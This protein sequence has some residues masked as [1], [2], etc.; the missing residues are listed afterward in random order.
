MLSFEIT[1]GWFITST[2]ATLDDAVISDLIAVRVYPDWFKEVTLEWQIPV[3]WGAYTVDVYKSGSSTTEYVKVTDAPSRGNTWAD[4]DTTQDS[5]Q[6]VDYYIIEVTLATGEIYRSH[7]AFVQGRRTRWAHIRA[8]E[9]SRRE[10]FMLR[11]FMGV[12]IVLLKRRTYGMR[13]RECWSDVHKKVMEDNCAT[14]AG[15]S[16]EQ[17]YFPGVVSYFQ[18]EPNSRNLQYTYFGKLESNQTSCWTTSL[19]QLDPDDIVIR[20]DDLKVFRIDQVR[21]TEL[22][23]VK[24]RQIAAVSELS[25]DAP[26]FIL[27]QRYGLASDTYE[28]SGLTH[29]AGEDTSGTIVVG[30]LSSNL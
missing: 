29:E 24:V 16:F 11:K 19:P 13:C 3:E 28:I 20:L 1:A 23:S 2:A 8:N 25:H 21:Q 30:G 10:S 26:E 17:G 6:R 4:W 5:N 27:I 7:P 15:T 22:Q 12:P 18:F 14:C 9:I